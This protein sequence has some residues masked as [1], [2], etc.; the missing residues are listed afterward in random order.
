MYASGSDGES[1]SSFFDCPTEH[2]G[3]VFILD[4][5]ISLRAS[6]SITMTTTTI[7]VHVHSV[8][9]WSLANINLHFLRI[10]TLVQGHHAIA[11]HHQTI[12]GFSFPS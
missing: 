6:S 12:H 7:I 9:S 4:D 1:F 3:E 8:S 5:L 2:E 11:H 10:V